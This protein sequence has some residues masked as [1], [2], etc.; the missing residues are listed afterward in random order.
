MGKIGRGDGEGVVCQNR[1]LRGGRCIGSEPGF[2]GLEDFQ[3]KRHLLVFYS[4]ENVKPFMEDEW[5]WRKKH[6]QG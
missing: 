6:N 5:G 1:G 3:D 2:S 4:Y